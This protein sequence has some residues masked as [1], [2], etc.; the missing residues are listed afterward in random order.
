VLS[1]QVKNYLSERGATFSYNS[2]KVFSTNN[3]AFDIWR[4]IPT[5][6]TRIIGQGGG[7]W[8]AYIIWRVASLW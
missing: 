2:S 1:E 5:G 6:P 7:N 4:N 3:P 8:I